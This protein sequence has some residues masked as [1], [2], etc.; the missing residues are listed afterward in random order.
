[1]K[2]MINSIIISNSKVLMMQTITILVTSNKIKEI[3]KRIVRIRYNKISIKI[4]KKEFS[5]RRRKKKKKKIIP[6]RMIK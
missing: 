6:V 2:I 3:N 1:M 5:K 4:S